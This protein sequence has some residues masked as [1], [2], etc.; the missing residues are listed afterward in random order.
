MALADTP[1]PIPSE[2]PGARLDRLIAPQIREQMAREIT[3]VGGS[4]VFFVCK[5]DRSLMIEEAEAYAF[6]NKG[7]VP[8][9]MQYARPGDVV[10]HNHPSG[11]LDPSDADI[12]VS[13][14]LGGRGVGSY[15]INND[16]SAVRIVVKALTQPK[17]K[18]I[19]PERLANLLRPG[20]KLAERLEGYEERPQQIAMIRAIAEAFNRD[21]LAVIEAGTGTGKSMAYLLP[22]ILWA[23]QNQEKVVISTG[24]INLQE[25]LVHKDLPLLRQALGIEFETTLLK[26]R[27]NYL[28]MRK[29]DYLRKF[30]E[31]LDTEGKDQQ[32]KEIQGWVRTTNEG[33]REDLP[34]IP[35][36]DVWERVMSEADN[37]LRARCPFYQKCFFYSARRRAARAHVLVVNHHMLMADLAVRAESNNYAGT[38]VLPPFQRLILDEAHNLHEVATD[39]FG[40][41]SSRGALLYAMRRLHHERKGTGL[42]S[43]LAG[44][45]HEG[46]Y[47]LPPAERDELMLK[48]MRELPQQHTELRHAMQEA[49]EGL[50]DDFERKLD[51]PLHAAAESKRRVKE[52]D[53]GTPFWTNTIEEPLRSV[54]TAARPYLEG[55]RTVGKALA[56]FLEEGK[57]EVATPILELQSTLRKVEGVIQRIIRFLGAGEGH[58]R[59]LE[60]RRRANGRSAD[61]VF[62]IAPLEISGQIR[63]QVLRRFRTVA[64][65]S[66]T[67]TVEHK[68]DYFLRQIGADNPLLLGLT[69]PAAQATPAPRPDEPRGGELAIAAERAADAPEAE[70]GSE[71]PDALE[72][73]PVSRLLQTLLLDT[74]FDYARQVYVGVPSDL[75]EPTQAGF[76]EALGRFLAPAL[77]A[78]RGRAFVLFTAY[79]AL[80]QVH[81]QIAPELERDGYPCLRQGQTGRGMLTEMFRKHIGSVL[82]A[83]SSFWEGVDVQGEALSCLVLA[84]LPFGVPDDPLTE[85]RIEALQAQGRNAFYELT[86]P[87]AVIKFRQGFGR[88]IRSKTD[89]GVVIICDNRVMNKQYGKMFLRSLPTGAVHCQPGQKL[90]GELQNFLAPRQTW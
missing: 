84:R 89:R 21:G 67:L 11:R 48:L 29:A 83:T 57:P 12:A 43:F 18:P 27:N 42:M 8:A 33:S 44:K 36:D 39:Y 17:L 77:R 53:L 26:G 9:L 82:F 35:D 63:E 6:G 16:C 41:R 20:G 50:T 32:L 69:G 31:F 62:C 23:V 55:L 19:D 64:M 4:E 75:P 56:R 72:A 76:N 22:A 54:V 28:C 74:P 58:C 71:P 40:A 85:A 46:F 2:E 14:E 34:F 73:A 38:A 15:I 78:T 24:T 7:A 49:V 37:C 3:E 52:A 80:E 90:V 68:F 60:Y 61:V 1:T 87:Q 86:V 51:L 25:Q 79:R 45:L 70:E 30:P 47:P 88:L 81:A 13:S 59:W 10:V 5:L 66:A 65:T